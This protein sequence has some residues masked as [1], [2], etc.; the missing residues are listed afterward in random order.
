MQTTDDRVAKLL[1]VGMALSSELSVPAL[2]Q[3]V[4]DLA[5]EVTRAR[6]AALGV[7]GPDGQLSDFLT[8]GV[9]PEQH[10]AIGE[11]PRGGGILGVIID[12]ARLLRLHDIAADPRSVGF[13]PNHPPMHTFLGAP[14]RARGQV[15]GNLYLTEKLGGS[16]FTTEDEEA[17]SILATQ[18]GIAIA[19]ARLYAE[20][21]R[22]ARW[23]EAVREIGGAILSG[24]GVDEVLR[25]VA[26]RARELLSADACT[27]VTPAEDGAS[28]VISVA[29]GAHAAKL[30]GMAVPLDGSISGEA[31]QTGL[32]ILLDNASADRRTHQP[33]VQAGAMGPAL[34]MPMSVR[35]Q[36]LGTLAISNDVGRPR[37]TEDD[38]RVLASFADQAA[39]G[40]EYARAQRQLARLALAEDRERIAKDLHDG[41]IQSLF[42]VGLGL[43]GAAGR[44]SDPGVGERIHEAV[45]E[46]DNVIADLRNYIFGL[47]PAVLAHRRLSEALDQLGHEFEAHSG[48]TTVVEVDGSLEEPLAEHATH[49]VQLTREALSNVGR[50]AQAATVR[51]SLRRQGR[52]AILEIDDDGVGYHPGEVRD[53]GMGV[54][55][56]HERA[57]AMGGELRV[58]SRPSE[59]TMVRVTLPL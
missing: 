30:E 35:G 20:T 52:R 8:T 15:Y 22:R 11:L 14:V 49:L 50:H 23:L 59:G 42:A 48:V 12:D 31:M 46:I 51:V 45:T 32:P 38:V 29:D 17:L 25:L 43:Q 56:M 55:N 33:M 53:A 21:E 13:P 7:L 41:V 54:A 58:E 40:F 3:R 26:R 28:L 19:N 47:R 18:A 16:D 5:G 39:L 27:V 4:V 36:A 24:G 37:F 1:D 6:Y 44:V 10:A 34:F 57:E 2:L 9:T